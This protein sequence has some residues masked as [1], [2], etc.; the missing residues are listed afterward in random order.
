MNKEKE[1]E[2]SLKINQSILSPCD[3]DSADAV[4]FFHYGKQGTRRAFTIEEPISGKMQGWFCLNTVNKEEKAELVISL[5]ELSK[6]AKISFIRKLLVLIEEGK[7]PGCNKTK[8]KSVLTWDYADDS[9]DEVF[10][11]SGFHFLGETEISGLYPR[12]KA[13]IREYLW[14]Q[15]SSSA[16]QNK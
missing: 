13:I 8:V 6:E 14:N 4:L 12:E 1:T 11:K 2:S 16:R 9:D 15:E 3:Q 10:I 5:Y 7:L